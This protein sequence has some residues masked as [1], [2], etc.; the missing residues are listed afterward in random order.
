DRRLVERPRRTRRALRVRAGR[1]HGQGPP[2][3]KLQGLDLEIRRGDTGIQGTVGR[4]AV[5]P[6]GVEISGIDLKGAAGTLRG[7]VSISDKAIRIDI[8]GEDV[9]L[10]RA[11]QALGLP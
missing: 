5:G 2:A 1:R 11:A 3:P 6:A 7:E 4:V 8:E 9:D 10:E